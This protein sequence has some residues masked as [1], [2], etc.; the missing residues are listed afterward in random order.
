MCFSEDG[1]LRGEFNN[2][3]RSL[4]L[5]ADKHITIIEAL[6]RK[7]KGLSRQE[8]IA[9]TKFQDGGGLTRI[10]REL[11]ESNFIRHYPS[12]GLKE[13]N[14]LY[15]L[16]DVY[17]LFYLKWI[18]RTSPLDLNT[19]I[20]SLDS[21]A[22][23]AWSGYAFEQVC[24]SHIDS[25]KKALGISGVQTQTSSWNGTDTA[26]GAQ[27]DLLIDRRDHVINLC[28]MKFSMHPFTIDKRYAQSLQNKIAVFKSQTGTR[29]AIYLTLIT[30]Y[31]LSTSPYN[32]MVQNDLT[33]EVLFD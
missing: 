7:S 13:K 18:R 32:S 24:L 3:Y 5:N 12:F 15:Q 25:I 17:S 31:G 22:Q 14:A 26:G 9:E 10:L 1:L 6:S 23:R 27:I 21:P 28:E 20:N 8:L 29:K 16:T 11:E 19:W 2:L 30:T 33:M 4:F